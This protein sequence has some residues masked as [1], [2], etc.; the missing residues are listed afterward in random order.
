VPNVYVPWQ[1][2]LLTEGL[3]LTIEPMLCTGAGATVQDDDGWTV[4]TRDGGLAAHYEH[5][6]VIT[7]DRAVLL[8]EERAEG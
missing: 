2:D 1:R 3:V 8:T 7:R 5:T 6:L 4:R